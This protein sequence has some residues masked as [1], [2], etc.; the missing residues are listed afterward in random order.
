MGGWPVADAHRVLFISDP[1]AY[2]GTK[3][4]IP[5][6]Y[7]RAANEPGIE[8]WHTNPQSVIA[9]A[10]LAESELCVDA[11]RLIRGS[12]EQTYYDV[13]NL[14]WQTALPL[15]EF[16]LV[17]DRTLKPFPAGFMAALSR[18]GGKVTFVNDPRSITLHLEPRFQWM[19]AGEYAIP[20]VVT[21]SAADAREFF[22]THD[23]HVVVKL[24]GSC[25]GAA[26][27]QLF[28]SA[29]KVEVLG[30]REHA[31]FADFETAFLS[32]ARR[33]EGAVTVQ[34]FQREVT[35]GDKRVLVVGGRIIG[36]YVRRAGGWLQNVSLGGVCELSDVTEQER[37]AVARSAAMY[38]A[39]GIHL[40]GY[41]FL[42]GNGGVPL[43]SEINAG[44]IGGL[45]R[46]EALSGV[47][48]VSEFLAYL[49][50]LAAAP[51]A[52]S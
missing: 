51:R 25:G 35:R 33:A 27:Y 45:L 40:L 3:T 50:Q 31:R 44:N 32:V 14:A 42:H 46:L 21:E 48:V 29:R 7:A 1:E 15:T 38:L 6:V 30:A 17:F 52:F 10:A 8:L 9:T 34:E 20:A 23:E 5:G 16:D 18:W 12:T 19:A 24:P 43:I 39:R 11:V 13:A 41:D 4:D 49:K 22:D 26:V 47:P 2:R 28:R 37:A 36:A